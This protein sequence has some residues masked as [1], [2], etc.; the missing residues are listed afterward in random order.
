MRTFVSQN[1][2]NNI[3]KPID[4]FRRRELRN[5]LLVTEQINTFIATVIEKNATTFSSANPAVEFG[6]LL[7]ALNSVD[8]ARSTTTDARASAS[9]S[10]PSA[11]QGNV[12]I[13]ERI[14][15]PINLADLLTVITD[16]GH[17]S[18]AILSLTFAF[19]DEHL[20]SRKTRKLDDDGNCESGRN[21]NE[22]SH[23]ESSS[24]HRDN[25]KG[26]APM[27]DVNQTSLASAADASAGGN[28]WLSGEMFYGLLEI[29]SRIAHD[30]LYTQFARLARVGEKINGVSEEGRF[31]AFFEGLERSRL[32][33]LLTGRRTGNLFFAINLNL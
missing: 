7:A 4:H 1:Q 10:L 26:K 27:T 5:L 9:S 12:N 18:G 16:F 20:V 33:K 23:G 24:G 3:I 25:V 22:R 29:V 14:P 17:N 13:N 6:R 11:E 28:K 8:G 31:S 19:D 15:V 32:K 21:K 30:E 2:Q